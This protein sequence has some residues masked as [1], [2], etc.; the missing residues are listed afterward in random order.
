MNWLLLLITVATLFVAGLRSLIDWLNWKRSET[1]RLPLE[2]V[3][4]YTPERFEES[5][6][7][8]GATTKQRLLERSIWTTTGL[9]FL[10]A[11]GFGAVDNF[12]R[13]FGLGPV[14]T[15]LIFFLSLGILSEI[16]SIPFGYYST[17]VTEEKFGFNRS[18]LST[19]IGDHVKG[20]VLGILL[21]G[22]ILAGLL[23]FFAAAG[24]LAWIYAWAFLAVTQLVIG[25]LAPVLLM[26]LFNK[27]TPLPAGELKEAIEGY[28]RKVDFK[29]QGIFTMDGSKRSAK[30]NAIFTGLGRFRRIVLFDTLVK[31]HPRDE[32]V[33]VLAHEVG[34][35]KKG[36]IPRMIVASLL[37]LFALFFLL[38][39]VLSSPSASAALGFAQHSVHAGLIVAFWL[40]GPLSLVLGLLTQRLSRKHEFEADEYAA[41]TTGSATELA[42]ALKRLSAES[43]S[44]L[45]PHPWKVWLEYSHPPVIQRVRVLKGETA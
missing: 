19:F 31:Q 10:W 27:F 14:A 39:L 2:F 7:Y 26:P 11:G 22:P 5:K 6:A 36:H 41:R 24:S 18:S 25:F 40:Y 16:L 34:H 45:D 35:F 3:G 23:W 30:A 33:A 28:A 42:E 29:L 32:L 13:G 9:F 1:S 21:G 43:L 17:F 12:A 38:S 4:I 8:L 20:W 37:S 15:G 44:N